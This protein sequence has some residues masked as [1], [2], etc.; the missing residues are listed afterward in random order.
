MRELL[1]NTDFHQ[2]T[3]DTAEAIRERQFSSVDWDRVAE[4][5][6]SLGRAE[7]NA[8]RSHLAQLMYHLLKIK[9]QPDRKTNSWDR[10]VRLQKR[11][12]ASLLEEQPSLKNVLAQPEFWQRA[13][14]NAVA[15]SGPENLPDKVVDSFPETCPFTSTILS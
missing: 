5:I 14:D 11:E 3:T 12:I 6:H 13:Y 1:V 10:T 8:L 4:E 15:M 9:H 2:W 7:Q